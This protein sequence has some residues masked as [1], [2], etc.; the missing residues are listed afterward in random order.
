MKQG[1]GKAKGAEFERQVCK[2]LSKWISGVR[3]DDL[4]WRSAMSGGRA[5]LGLKEGVR[6][7]A[8]SGDISA[9]G[10]EA[11]QLISVYSIECK[12]VKDL[13][14]QGLVYG[15]KSGLI[16]HW[17]QACCEASSVGK[18]PMLVAKQNHKP[19]IVGLSRA[20]YRDGGGPVRRRGLAQMREA[21]LLVC[22]HED[23]NVMFF[24]D[25]L[26]LPP[27]Y[28]LWEYVGS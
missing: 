13:N 14:I 16:D 12:F 21:R 11:H 9:I 2:S 5:T 3:R 20:S 18:L 27:E 24:N 28:L 4:L 17:G 19:P 8:Q 22:P 7:L 25:M 26:N 6:R 1:G 15:T 23:L 10:L